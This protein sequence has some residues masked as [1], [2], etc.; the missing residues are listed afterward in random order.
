MKLRSIALA[1]LLGA[2]LLMSAGCTED[3]VKDAINDLVKPNAVYVVNAYGTESITAYA[4]SESGTVANG[5][6]K[7]FALAGEGDTDV[8]YTVGANSSDHTSLAYG[9]AHLY[10]ASDKCNVGT[11]GFG[12][13]TDVSSGQGIVKLVN[14][15]D[16][17]LTADS[18]NTVTVHVTTSGTTTDHDL[19]LQSGTTVAA[20]NKA[21]STVTIGDLGIVQGSVVSVTIGNTTSDPYTVE[22]NVPTTVDVDIVYLGGEKAVAVPL[23][24]WDDLLNN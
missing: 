14:A 21:T 4:D 5:D 23:V 8:Y 19:T 16:T 22:D 17:E 13:M 15:T 20:C 9:N 11:N 18:T 7:V 24:K 10:V 12:K 3:D 6:L 1:G 2:G